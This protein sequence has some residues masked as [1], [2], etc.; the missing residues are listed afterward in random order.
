MIAISPDKPEKL[1]KFQSKESLNFTLLSDEDH[2]IA[3]K[4]GAWGLKKFMGKEYMG[5]LRYTF[6]IDQNL[7]IANIMTKVKTKTHHD[8][9]IRWIKNNILNQG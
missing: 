6:I 2:V 3:E 8:D 1:L 4:Y 7:R 5:I 9:S